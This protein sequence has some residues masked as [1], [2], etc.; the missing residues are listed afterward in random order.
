MAPAVPAAIL[1]AALERHIDPAGV[2]ALAGLSAAAGAVYLA[3]YLS[4]PAATAER[5]LLSDV[6]TSGSKSVRRVLLDPLK[7]R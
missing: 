2:P 4:M 3:G 5:A 1:L 7:V 6:V